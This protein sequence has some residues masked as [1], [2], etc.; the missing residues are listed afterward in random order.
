MSPPSPASLRETRRLIDQFL[1]G[2]VKKLGLGSAVEDALLA[3][4]EQ[5]RHGERRDAVEAAI[6]D[7]ALGTP[8]KIAQALEVGEL[9]GR[10]LA[11]GA[12][13]D[14]VG[15]VLAQRGIDQGGA[16]GDLPARLLLPR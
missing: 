6:F 8:Q 10:V 1:R 4:L 5:H 13:Q 15:L 14:V 2:D 16:E 3:D 9:V 12:Q 11:R 7:A